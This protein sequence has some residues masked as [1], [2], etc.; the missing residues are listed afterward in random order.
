MRS[1]TG[2][3]LE[4]FS[5][6]WD[7][8]G[9]FI[10]VSDSRYNEIHDEFDKG[11]KYVDTALQGGKKKLMRVAL[12]GRDTLVIASVEPFDPPHTYLIPQSARD[13]FS[14]DL[15]DSCFVCAKATPIR[16]RACHD[17]FYCSREC[18]RIDWPHHR[19]ECERSQAKNKP[20]QKETNKRK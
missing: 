6:T 12:S 18:Q 13:Y 8:D 16:C 3:Q 5:E 9:Q 17:I 2:Q 7:A 10:T 15:V 1:I 20:L 4:A 19:E 14:K 11:N